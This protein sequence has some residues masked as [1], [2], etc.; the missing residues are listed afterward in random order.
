MT[1][2]HIETVLHLKRLL[3]LFD[4]PLILSGRHELTVDHPTQH[5]GSLDP[6]LHLHVL[7]T[8]H[9]QGDHVPPQA[10]APLHCGAQEQDE[11][12]EDDGLEEVKTGESGLPGLDVRV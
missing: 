3:E 10:V 7:E 4:D 12:V 5:L 6:D 2:H 9:H 8:L 1:A 11:V